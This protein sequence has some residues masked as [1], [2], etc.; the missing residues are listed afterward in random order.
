MAIIR[1]A[2]SFAQLEERVMPSV[3]SA[4]PQA[5]IPAPLT[6]LIGRDRDVA[7]VAALLRDP[8]IRLVTLTGP[9]GVG[10]TRLALN[11]LAETGSAFDDQALVV[12]LAAISDPALVVPTI[13][14]ALDLREEGDRPLLDRLVAVLHLGPVLLVLDNFEQVVDAAPVVVDLL[15]ECPGLKVLVTSRIALRVEGEQE[16]PVP[17]L[18]LPARPIVSFDE[19]ATSDAVT[20][21]V[22]RARAVR[23]DFRLTADN[24]SIIVEICRRLDGL[25]LAIELAAARTKLLSPRALLARLEQRL[26]LLTSGLRNVPARHQTMRNAIA[27]SYDLLN[28]PLQQLFRQLAVFR[29]GWTLE[30]AEAVIDPTLQAAL[31]GGLLGGMAALVE[32][33]LVEQVE[34]PDGEPRFRVLETIREYAHEQLTTDPRMDDV[35]RRHASW[36]LALAEASEAG[37]AGGEAQAWSGRVEIEHDNMRAALGWLVDSCQ[38]SDVVTAQLLTSALL[39]F[40]HTH[41]HFSEARAWARRALA[42]GGSG[43]PRA[44]ALWTAAWF[45]WTQD[46]LAESQHHNE[47]ALSIWESVGDVGG[48][49]LGRYLRGLLAIERGDYHEATVLIDDA[50]ALFRQAAEPLWTPIALNSLGFVAY[51]QGDIQ[52]AEQHIEESLTVYRSIGGR[53]DEAL[54]QTN[55]ARIA[56]DQQDYTRAAELYA[57]SLVIH[58]RFGEREGVAGNLRGLATIAGLSGRPEH[59]A[60]LLGAAEGLRESI[61]VSVPP[62]GRARHERAI[63][64]I[65]AV[66]TPEEFE[67]AWARGRALSLD[68]AIAAGQALATELVASAEQPPSSLALS[69]ADR[70]GLSPRELDVLRLVAQDL[71]T[72]DIA[73]RLFLSPRTVTT[74]LTSIYNKLGFNSRAAATRFAIE[75]GLV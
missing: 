61:G 56:R 18:A 16:F 32:Q 65:R 9:G 54:A 42:R 50:V 2:A 40:W 12:A 31:N 29:G 44:K 20:L 4:H 51:Q 69:P 38:P 5:R 17:P 47:E 75:H 22:Q 19:I 49:A 21:F 59:A 60:R 58:A 53:W 7:A 39:R 73:T 74:H 11:L 45:A 62:L 57:R 71:S 37:I 28:P 72:A 68:G 14:Q 41:S 48:I 67:A 24:A 70:H 34:Q 10:K 43:A 33:S 26:E 1:A 6:A 13:A 8:D 46:D 35:R 25:P 64:A 52:R 55:L 15:T 63:A 30:A 66:L 27:W 3:S 36:C 23:P